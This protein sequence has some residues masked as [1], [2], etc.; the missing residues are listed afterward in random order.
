MTGAGSSTIL[1]SSR[2]YSIGSMMRAIS[3]AW[4]EETISASIDQLA[5]KHAWAKANLMGRDRGT[6]SAD[7]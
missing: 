5:L 1:R 7:P 2:T 6:S 3:R 4:A